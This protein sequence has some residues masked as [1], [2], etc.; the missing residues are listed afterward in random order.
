[1]V[2]YDKKGNPVTTGDLEVGNAMI[3]WMLPSINPTLMQ[4]VEGQP[5]FVHAGPF[6]NIAVGQCSIV[7]DQIGLK[8][9][10]YHVTES[11][12]GADIGFEKFWNVKC[13]FSGLIPNVSVLTATVRGLKHHGVNA[14]ALPCPPGKPVPKEY[15]SSAKETMKWLEE[16]VQNAVHHVRTIK[17]AGINPVVC[18]NAF[19]FDSDEEHDR[20]SPGLRGG[21]RPG[22]GVQALAV[23]RRRRPGICRCGHGRLQRQAEIQVPLSQRAAPAASALS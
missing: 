22:G 21:R 6:A 20:D 4:T 9:F 2:A 3:A 17:K 12:F 16:G 10:D 15:F 11:G 19:H 23:R 5:C 7:A 14:G 13:R 1:M 18:I 8:L